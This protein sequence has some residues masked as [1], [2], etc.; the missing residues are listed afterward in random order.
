[1][2]GHCPEITVYTGCCN[3]PSAG[4]LPTLWAENKK[5]L[6]SMLVEV[7][8]GDLWLYWTD[9]SFGLL[10]QLVHFHWTVFSFPWGG[11]GWGW[12]LGSCLWSLLVQFSAVHVEL[13]RTYPPGLS[14]SSESQR[15]TQ[16]RRV[17]L[18][19]LFLSLGTQS[20]GASQSASSPSQ[21]LSYPWSA[22]PGLCCSLLPFLI[23]PFMHG[24][25]LGLMPPSQEMGR[26]LQLLAVWAGA[27]F[28]QV[29]DSLCPA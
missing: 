15:K 3:F 29:A 14:P 18:A 21:A 6:L 23:L 9:S 27:F 20:P 28:S 12:V 4:Q 13:S 1:M 7:S 10:I 19:L 25:P 22:S 11:V 8:F 17:D 26:L 24:S 2:Y 16:G 5:S